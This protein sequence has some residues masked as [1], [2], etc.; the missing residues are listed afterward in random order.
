MPELLKLIIS[1]LAA[2]ITLAVA[3]RKKDP[4]CPT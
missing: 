4:G 3:V 2:V 1:A